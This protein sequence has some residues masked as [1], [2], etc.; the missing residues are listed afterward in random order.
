MTG[1]DEGKDQCVMVSALAVEL[2]SVV[3]MMIRLSRMHRQ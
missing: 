2:K 1:L 3:V